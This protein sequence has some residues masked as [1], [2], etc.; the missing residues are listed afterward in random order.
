MLGALFRSTSWQ[1]NKSELLF[2]VTPRLAK[3]IAGPV[4]LPTDDYIELFDD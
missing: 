1:T 3:P 2:V 4:R